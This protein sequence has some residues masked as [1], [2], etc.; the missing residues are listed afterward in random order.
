MSGGPDELVVVAQ[1]AGAFGVK[2]EVRVRPFTD[3]PEAC[4]SYGPLMND[5]GEVVLTPVRYRPLKDLFG[6]TAKEALQREEWEALKGTNL[7]VRRASLPEPEDNEYYVIDLIG[8]EVVHAD[9][10]QLGL[11]RNVPDFG[12]GSLLEITP[13]TGPSFYLPFDAENAPGVDLK[14]RR[15]TVAPDEELLPEAL[16]R[17]SSDGRTN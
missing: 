15:I 4:L 2:G 17:Q 9:G 8:C 16:Q 1:I 5:K 3:D 12:A 7:H 10:R 14:A 13:A 6:V 11:V